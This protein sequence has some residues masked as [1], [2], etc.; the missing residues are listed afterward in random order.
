MRAPTADSALAFHRLE[1]DL[2]RRRLSAL[3]G[4]LRV[5]LALIGL[6]VGAFTFWQ[7]RIPFAGAAHAAGASAVA[8]EMAIRLG[9]LVAGGA[10]IAGARHAWVLHGNLPG[11]AW[12]ALPVPA[13]RVHRHLV[14]GS[15][16]HALWPALPALAV[17]LAAWGL[18]PPAWLALAAAGFVWL[19]LESAR[20]ACRLALVL[21]RAGLGPGPS[22]PP[23][24]RLLARMRRP[25]HRE[26]VRPAAWRAESAWRAIARKDATVSLRPGLP[27]RRLA[28][29]LPWLAAA[30]VLWWLPIEPRLLHF[31]GFAMSLVAAGLF[32][33]WLLALAGADPFLATRILP[34]PAAPLWAARA[35]WASLVAAAI[36]LA[37]AGAVRSLAPQALGVYAVWVG[38]ATLAVGLLAVHYGITLHPRAD[39]A[40]R[41]YGLSLGLAIAASL[42][43]P[44][45]GWIVLLTAVIHS[46]R[47]VPRWVRPEIV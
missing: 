35:A 39:E 6:L 19:L 26:R 5:E 25:A 7:A 33:E 3:D 21:A 10:S 2:V 37:Q 17:I 42:M 1:R 36:L 13:E 11:P 15:T 9:L 20:L 24:V 22:A 16:Q 14:W 45:M 47:R 18:V 28:A 41:L 46:L 4:V 23:L 31:A 8:R 44:L 12:L 30:S 27:R 29:A 38:C 43:I 40:R 32:G 34:V